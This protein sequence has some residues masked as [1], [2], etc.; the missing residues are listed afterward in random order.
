MDNK[1]NRKM[2][3]HIFWGLINL[4]LLTFFVSCGNDSC[5]ESIAENKKASSNIVSLEEAKEELE[6]LLDDTYNS[7]ATRGVGMSKKIIANAFTINDN[8]SVT[9]SSE[10]TPIIHIFNFTNKEGFAIMAGNREMPS[11]LALADS[12]EISQTEAIDNPGFAIF[13][14]NMEE[15]YKENISTYSNASTYK[16]YGNWKNLVYKPNGYCKVKWGQ[17]SP[18]NACCPLKNGEQTL[19]GCVATAVAQLMT[20][21]K[22]PSSHNGYSYDWTAMTTNAN[23]KYCTE[24][25]QYQI[26]RLM[27]ELGTSENL[28][29]SY[30]TN[31]NGGSGA[32]SE[33]IPRT[34]KNFGYSDGGKLIDYNTET[35]VSELKNKHCVL[36]SGFSHK[37]V[38]KFLGIKVKT[39]YSGGHQWLCHGLLKRERLVETYSSDGVLQ[40]TSMEEEWYVLCNW[41][42]NGY[43]DGYYLSKAFNTVQGPTYPDTRSIDNINESENYNYQYKIQAIVGIRR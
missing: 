12:G 14:E 27:I 34:F 38:K 17:G 24:T 21:Y 11:L 41:G 10:E 8:S 4:F 9:R 26:A 19:T 5:I 43:Q 16:V 33:N 40:G 7:S 42:W 3:K 18:Y 20:I 28:N 22:Y 39:S 36:V 29:M 6:Q 1:R 2:E 32:K 15:K 23:G 25:G 30:N 35:I 31:A 13:L 37:K